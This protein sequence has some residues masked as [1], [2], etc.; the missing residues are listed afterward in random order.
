[1]GI[2][3][4]LEYWRKQITH[5]TFGMEFPKSHD[6][7]GGPGGRGRVFGRV[8]RLWMTPKRVA[9]SS[10]TAID[11]GWVATSTKEVAMLIQ[12][13]VNR[14]AVYKTRGT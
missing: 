8:S 12:R 2:G 5:K 13:V 10:R 14:V 7:A 3:E 4:H 6:S 11:S 1:M 9:E